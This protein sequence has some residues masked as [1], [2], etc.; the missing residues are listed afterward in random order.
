MK[1]EP[2][3][4]ALAACLT[5]A[6]AALPLAAQQRQGRGFSLASLNGSYGTQEAGDGTVAVGLG[7]VEYDGA[8]KA[9]RKII[10]NAPDGAGGRRLLVFESAGTYTVNPDGTGTAAFT[11]TSPNPGAVDTFDFVIT[12]S[13]AVWVAGHGQSRV[14]TELVGAQR[15]AGVTVSLV[16]SVQK[17]IADAA[18]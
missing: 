5:V 11:N 10:V 16:T 14:A 6:V 8:G 15:E 3:I 2:K 9:S 7:V 4:L 12:G 1:L 13:T 17:R 18:E